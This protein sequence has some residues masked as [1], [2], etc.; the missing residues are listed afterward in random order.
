MNRFMNHQRQMNLGKNVQNVR[1][2]PEEKIWV[3]A[4]V[5]SN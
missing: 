1:P 4:S 5:I 3:R 2:L